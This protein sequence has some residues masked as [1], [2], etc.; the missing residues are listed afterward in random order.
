M[1]GLHHTIAGGSVI[2]M[3]MSLGAGAGPGT[4]SVMLRL[5]DV[6][7]ESA[8]ARVGTLPWSRTGRIAFSSSPCHSTQGVSNRTRLVNT[9]I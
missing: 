1:L 6:L 5:R 3:L 8:A 4:G 2:E 9:A 7:F